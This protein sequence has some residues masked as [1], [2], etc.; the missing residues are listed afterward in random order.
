MDNG[1]VARLQND[2]PMFEFVASDKARWSP[3]E[4]K[5]YYTNDGTQTLHELGHAIL[6][7]REYRQ[8]I[9]LLQIER[10]AWNVAMELAPTYGLNIDDNIV[11]Q[12]LDTYRDWL[13]QRSLCP[14]CGQTGVQSINTL[15]YSCPNCQHTWRATAGKNTRLK[16]LSI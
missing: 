5:I 10:E 13:H 3:T 8:D 2:Y 1:L 12:A 14:R 7:H 15:S 11:E 4:Q 16:R 6:G 9:E